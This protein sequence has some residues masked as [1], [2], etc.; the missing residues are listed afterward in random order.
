MAFLCYITK[1]KTDKLLLLVWL[2]PQIYMVY[3]MYN[4][5]TEIRNTIHDNLFFYYLA[6]TPFLFQD[7]NILLL[8]LAVY[9]F[10]I[11]TRYI[12]NRCIFVTEEAYKLKNLK[13]HNNNKKIKKGDIWDSFTFHEKNLVMVLVV[14]IILYKLSYRM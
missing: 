3:E 10:T 6:I 12:F 2:I 9:I 8:M 7:K 5:N 4:G 1:C 13:D 14:L 11:S